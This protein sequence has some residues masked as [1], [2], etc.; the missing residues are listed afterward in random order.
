MVRAETASCGLATAKN[1]ELV[2][3]KIDSAARHLGGLVVHN[4]PGLRE[5]KSELEMEFVNTHTC[6]PTPA[7]TNPATEGLTEGMLHDHWQATC[8]LA[9]RLLLSH[10][11]F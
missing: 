11:D 10:K 1:G 7:G 3:L 4:S 9:A 2:L 6:W 8:K 5:L